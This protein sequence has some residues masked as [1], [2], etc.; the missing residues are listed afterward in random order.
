M[1]VRIVVCFGVEFCAVCTLCT[2]SYFIEV[3][4]TEWPTFGTISAH[5]V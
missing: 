4:V 5:S 1:V 2:F 3:W